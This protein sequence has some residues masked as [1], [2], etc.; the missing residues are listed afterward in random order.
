MD[1]FRFLNYITKEILGSKKL[2][3]A[4]FVIGSFVFFL[5]DVAP[6]LEKEDYQPGSVL[7][8]KP[9]GK[10]KSIFFP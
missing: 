5:D 6:P 10:E 3:I 7:K 4:F 2:M 8:E 9:F 1:F